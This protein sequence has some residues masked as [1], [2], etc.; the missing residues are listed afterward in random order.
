[1]HVFSPKKIF[2]HYRHSTADIGRR[3][4]D[5]HQR[6]LELKKATGHISPTNK[7]EDNQWGMVKWYYQQY[8]DFY[9]VGTA[10]SMAL[11][12]KHDNASDSFVEFMFPKMSLLVIGIVSSVTAAASR[13]PMS[14][15]SDLSEREELNPDRFGSGSKVYVTSSIVQLVVIQIWCLFIVYTSFITG[16]RL[17]REPFL[18][19]RPAQLA[20]RVSCN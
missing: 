3:R 15:S 1:M 7:I 9:G 14:E 20:F 17:R 18:S 4:F 13:F 11:R 5:Q 8:G 2:I 16:E 10:H 12:M 6:V 19:T